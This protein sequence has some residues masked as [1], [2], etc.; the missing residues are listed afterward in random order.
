[1]NV[2][3]LLVALLLVG[4]AAAR[5]LHYRQPGRGSNHSS[6][7]HTGQRFS[8]RREGGAAAFIRNLQPGKLDRIKHRSQFTGSTARLAALLDKDPD[9]V[10]QQLACSTPLQKLEAIA[11]DGIHSYRSWG[12]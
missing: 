5:S 3:R 4:C 9:L 1:M 11:A 8:F 2:L 6:S 10:S 12:Q 7:V